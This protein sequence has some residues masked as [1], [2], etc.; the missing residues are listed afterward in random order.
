MPD[1]TIQF[2]H[3]QHYGSSCSKCYVTSVAFCLIT[4]TP[5]KLYKYRHIAAVRAR[6]LPGLRLGGGL[7]AVQFVRPLPEGPGLPHLSRPFISTHGMMRQPC[8]EDLQS[9]GERTAIDG[10]LVI[11]ESDRVSSLEAR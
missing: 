6:F 4:R 10:S 11:A 2:E 9:Y 3:K 8:D 1:L 5:G 7:G